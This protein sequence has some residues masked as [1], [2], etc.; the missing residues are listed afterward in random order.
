MYESTLCIDLGASYT[1]IAYRRSCVPNNVG[2]KSEDARILTIDGNPLIPSL[3]IK[4]QSTT[5]PWVFGWE[6]ANLTPDASMRVFYNWKA[7]LFRSKNDR[8]S[9]AAVIVAEHFF[10]WLRQKLEEADIQLGN[11]QTR[12]AMPAFESFDSKALVMA[13][14]M[15]MSGWASSLILKV[16]EPYANTIGLFSRGRNVVSRTR[17]GELLLNYGKM[18]SYENIWV[19]TARAHT[20]HGTRHNLVTTVVVDIGAFTTDLATITFDVTDPH[21]AG[22]GLQRIAQESHSLGVINDLDRPLFSELAARRGFNWAEVP[23]QLAEAA[24]RA[25]YRGKPFS[26][27]TRSTG[28]IQLGEDGD[29]AL[30]DGHLEAFSAALWSHLSPFID[31]ENPTLVYLTGGGSLIAPVRARLENRLRDRQVRIGSVMSMSGGIGTGPLRP[32]NQ[33]GEDLHRLATAL[34]GTSA[35]LQAN[36]SP[37]HTGRDM[38]IPRHP[39]EVQTDPDFKPCRC[40]GGNKDCCF[41]GGRGFYSP[42]YL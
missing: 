2:S 42:K 26:L 35:I 13:K 25:I 17:D 38:P 10:G 36:A 34:G 3:A 33:T 30:I 28:V 15:E 5:T 24:K 41:C 18:F 7:D 21:N 1:K 31:E 32:W 39:K 11:T 8:D 37:P 23:F 40:R 20:L 14:C 22:D 27:P 6:A 16:T 4:T 9:A 19:Q 12:I 29:R